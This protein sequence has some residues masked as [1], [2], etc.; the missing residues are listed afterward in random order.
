MRAGW[1]RVGAAACLGVLVASAAFSCGPYFPWQMLASREQT[2]RDLPV[3]SFATMAAQLVSR[4]PPELPA[5][6]MAVSVPDVA[7]AEQRLLAPDARA[8][9][10]RM[11]A[12]PNP[13]AALAAGAGLPAVVR[14]Y[15]AGAV[16]FAHRDFPG[17]AGRFR[18]ALGTAA[19]GPVV[20]QALWA[21]FMLGRTLAAM[22]DPSGAAAA[23]QRTRALAAGG[24]PDPMELGLASL[25]EEARLS[26][27]ASRFVVRQP[28]MPPASDTASPPPT[29]DRVAALEAATRL[30][31]QQA[32]YGSGWGLDSLQLVAETL[33]SDPAWL[34]QAVR[35]DLLRELV[36]DYALASAGS[37]PPDAD[38]QSADNLQGLDVLITNM[39]AATAASGV[40]NR[41]ATALGGPGTRGPDDDGRL[42]AIA[43]LRGDFDLAKRFLIDTDGPLADWV[44]AK[45]ALQESDL[46]AAAVAFDN[47]INWLRIWPATM[48]AQVT[49][50]LCA[51]PGVLAMA[52][53]DFPLAM[54]VFA[55]VDDPASYWGDTAYIAERVLTTDELRRFVA[56]H[57]A[58]VPVLPALH[59]TAQ[60]L[61]PGYAPAAP[62]DQ[63]RALRD[64]LARRLMR[65]GRLREAASFFTSADLQREA[66]SYDK[67]LARSR[68]AFWRTGRA[69]GAWDAAL[70]ARLDGMELFGTEIAPDLKSI[71]GIFDAG[72][73]P[74][75]APSGP[76][77]TGM[78]RRR[79]DASRPSPD[80]RF[81]YRYVAIG[82]ARRAASLLPARS[83]ASA[84][85]LCRAA[86][87]AFQTDDQE[88]A[89]DLYRDYVAHGAVVPWAT[90]FGFHCPAPD[91]AAASKWHWRPLGRRK[92][93]FF[94]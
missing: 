4:S 6:E 20:P 57:V 46:P 21:A 36:V 9:V 43:Y 52:R 91:F 33:I 92:G 10:A 30:Y 56:A 12:A 83:Q 39:P 62:F 58:P 34:A 81:H 60:D 93:F 78:E 50:R 16:A 64:L 41:M 88:L 31:A 42:A 2:M 79:Y 8:Q 55:A 23:F 89:H 26:L 51:E 53:G 85:I 73:G 11:R 44:R 17:A 86:G 25:G 74:A 69:R 76:Y 94:F 54:Q 47:A 82:H 18:A 35:H 19:Q 45:L 59:G 65:E 22:A 66:R 68:D 49:A 84:A 40:L 29:H 14:D 24:V 90:H 32:T 15:V 70:I 48:G 28:G 7:A 72:L 71:D 37:V 63:S 77:T 27:R 13:A 1:G 61:E 67:A 87:W 80:L 5:A 75:T 38:L 3:D